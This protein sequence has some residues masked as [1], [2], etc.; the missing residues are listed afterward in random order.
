[1]P[2]LLV[3]ASSGLCGKGAFPQSSELACNDGICIRKSFVKKIVPHLSKA[4][5]LVTIYRVTDLF[6]NHCLY[7]GTMGI[8]NQ[9]K[10]RKERK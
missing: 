4:R 3:Q 2:G 7:C 9:K 1:M 6:T 10:R 5:S 8:Y